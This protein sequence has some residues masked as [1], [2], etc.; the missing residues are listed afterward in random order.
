MTP[1]PPLTVEVIYGWP[2]SNGSRRAGRVNYALDL[3]EEPG[4]GRVRIR[5]D[6]H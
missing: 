2:L 3:E 1:S 6:V 5:A 4:A